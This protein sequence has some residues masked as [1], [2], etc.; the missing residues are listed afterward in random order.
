MGCTHY[1]FV[2]P[3]IEDITGPGVRTIDP[4]PAIARQ[5]RR[6]LAQKGLLN[7]SEQHGAMQFYTSGDPNALT[8][9]LPRLLGEAGPVD[10]INWVGDGEIVI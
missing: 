4:A 6:L 7:P 10:Q 1:P 5:V 3:Q 2:I 9:L 8:D